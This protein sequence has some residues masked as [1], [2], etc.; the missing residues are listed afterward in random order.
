MHARV[1]LKRYPVEFS[2]ED[3][4]SEVMEKI[5]LHC[6]Q[7]HN[8]HEYIYYYKGIEWGRSET[9]IKDAGYIKFDEDFNADDIILDY[10]LRCD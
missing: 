1:G 4:V 8:S 7:E 2:L 3:T 6:N 9:K 10:E 5:F